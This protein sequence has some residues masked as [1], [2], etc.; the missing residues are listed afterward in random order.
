LSDFER[1]LESVIEL[2]SSDAAVVDAAE[3]IP[4]SHVDALA[5]LGL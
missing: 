4:E 2:F 3:S 1:A 5:S